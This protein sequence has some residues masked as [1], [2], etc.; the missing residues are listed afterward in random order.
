[1]R[2]VSF[3]GALVERSAVTGALLMLVSVTGVGAWMV[4]RGS[5]FFGKLALL[6]GAPR[7][8]SARTLTH[9]LV[10]TLPRTPFR[11][12]LSEVL[13]LKTRLLQRYQT[14]PQG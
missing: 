4:F 1:M 5:M 2:Q 3:L 12:L 8:A 7:S 10:L 6:T 11:H 9:C 14:E 13:R